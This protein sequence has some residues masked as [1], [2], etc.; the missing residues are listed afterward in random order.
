MAWSDQNSDSVVSGQSVSAT[1]RNA[2]TDSSAMTVAAGERARWRSADLAV[3]AE[4]FTHPSSRLLVH[5]VVRDQAERRSDLALDEDADEGVHTRVHER[6]G[7]SVHSGVDELRIDAG[8]LGIGT[9]HLARLPNL[10]L[11]CLRELGRRCRAPLREWIA[12]HHASSAR[13]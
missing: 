4:L 5:G 13:A 3:P 11:H 1:V 10:G 12:G 6:G 2:P 8:G 7:G 9:Q